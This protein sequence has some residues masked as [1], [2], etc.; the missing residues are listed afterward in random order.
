[1]YK[2]EDRFLALYRNYEKG[3]LLFLILPI[4]G[5]ISIIGSS[6]L[7]DYLIFKLNNTSVEILGSIPTV[8]YQIIIC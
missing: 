7:C 1:M 4:I 2:D 5:L 8:V 3:K 6:F